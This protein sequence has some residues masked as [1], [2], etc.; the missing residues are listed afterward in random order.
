MVGEGVDPVHRPSNRA[1]LTNHIHS[2]GHRDF[3]QTS[4]FVMCT[5]QRLASTITS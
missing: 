4:G 1:I 3:G 2:A 5:N